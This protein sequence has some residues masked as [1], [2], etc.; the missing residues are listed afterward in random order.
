MSL[1]RA[2]SICRAPGEG[3]RAIVAMAE[4]NIHQIQRRNLWCDCDASAFG[5][6]N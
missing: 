1:D 4:R 3:N 6:Q 5:K 2:V